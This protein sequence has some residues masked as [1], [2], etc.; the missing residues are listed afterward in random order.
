MKG[1]DPQV[2][3]HLPVNISS[4]TLYSRKRQAA[5]RDRAAL[6]EASTVQTACSLWLCPFPE[7]LWWVLADSRR[8]LEGEKI[9]WQP[10][11]RTIRSPIS[12]LHELITDRF[13]LL[14]YFRK[15]SQTGFWNTWDLEIFFF[16]EGHSTESKPQDWLIRGKCV[17]GV[18]PMDMGSW[19]PALQF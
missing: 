14:Q 6:A 7:L 11:R 19:I 1:E 12:F 2:W 17:L 16:N 4:K 8:A 3:N 18:M 5:G 9:S 15:L 13:S 10:K